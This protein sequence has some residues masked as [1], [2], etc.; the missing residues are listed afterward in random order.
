MM[1]II[2]NV[3]LHVKQIDASS[4]GGQKLI[5]ALHSQLVSC[6]ISKWTS[7]DYSKIGCALTEAKHLETL[8]LSAR[9][10]R[11]SCIWNFLAKTGVSL[12]PLKELVLENY[13][14]HRPPY[15]ALH[16]WN[17]TQLVHLKLNN[18]CIFSFLTTVPYKN[19]VHLRVLHMY[20][21]C[22]TN[23]A[24]SSN[25]IC[26]L[27]DSIAPLHTLGIACMIEQPQAKTILSIRRQGPSLKVLVLIDCKKFWHTDWK[28]LHAWDMRGINVSCPNLMQ[29]SIDLPIHPDLQT[30]R[31]IL[32]ESAALA[33]FRNLRRLR[34]CTKCLQDPLETES[35]TWQLIGVSIRTW[36]KMLM[37]AKQGCAFES[38][39][40]MVLVE[41]SK[42]LGSHRPIQLPLASYTW[43]A[44]MRIEAVEK[45]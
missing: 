9:N 13:A 22:R 45:K 20:D 35:E 32:Y 10:R 8:H 34:I 31:P 43:L 39:R 5:N 14:W 40:V 23:H 17:W 27:L 16:V 38:I 15:A 26:N 30:P 33:H 21:R 7:P 24:Q 12:P 28:F 29:L 2:P 42:P 19:L 4:P 11:G 44:P 25:M 1:A 18:V 36:L 6:K 37:V 41:R 3:K